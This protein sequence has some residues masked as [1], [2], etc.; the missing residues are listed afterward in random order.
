MTNRSVAEKVAQ[1]GKANEPRNSKRDQSVKT[2]ERLDN[3]Y[4]HYYYNT[5]ATGV[6]DYFYHYK[7]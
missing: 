4:S 7:C 2:L 6:P 5:N 1:T 3:Y